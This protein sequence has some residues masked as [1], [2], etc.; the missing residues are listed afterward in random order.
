[1][2]H[3]TSNSNAIK[4]LVD[5]I[6][7]LAEQIEKKIKTKGFDKNG[8]ITIDLSILKSELALNIV[9][10]TGMVVTAAKYL[11]ELDSGIFDYYLFT[12]KYITFSI[13]NE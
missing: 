2:E 8:D 3:N 1:M 7:S 11:T 6:H 12:G 4:E 13:E 9:Y 10:E 5:D